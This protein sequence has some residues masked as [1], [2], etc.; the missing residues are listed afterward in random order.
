M[1]LPAPIDVVLPLLWLF[2]VVVS[3]QRGLVGLIAGLAGAVFIKP[4]LLLASFSAPLALVVA[5]LLGFLVT[6][7]VRPFPNLSYRQPRWG[8]LLGGLGGA[9][10]GTALLVTLLVSLPLGR[11]LN[12]AVRYPAAEIPFSALFERSRLVS[13]GRAILLYPLLAA[14]GDVSPENRGVLSALHT[15]FVVGQPWEEANGQL[16]RKRKP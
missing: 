3:A 13:L 4:L 6:L 15:M 16:S 12:G 11:D 2:I 5:L 8:H 7:A 14:S 10:L 1:T 9:V